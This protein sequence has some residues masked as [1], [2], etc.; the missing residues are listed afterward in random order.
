MRNVIHQSIFRSSIP[1]SG[2]KNQ[3]PTRGRKRHKNRSRKSWGISVICPIHKLLADLY[4]SLSP[5]KSFRVVITAIV[6]M[7]VVLWFLLSIRRDQSVVQKALQKGWEDDLCKTEGCR[8][9][10]GAHLKQTCPMT[11]RWGMR[12]ITEGIESKSVFI[13]LRRWCNTMIC[14]PWRVVMS[15]ETQCVPTPSFQLKK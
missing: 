3:N 10:R 1:T 8:H 12:K 11:L 13:R 5:I 6:M 14:T 2:E 7:V 9:G 4:G 15:T